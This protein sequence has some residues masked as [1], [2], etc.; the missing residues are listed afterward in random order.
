MKLQGIDISSILKP[1][2]KYVILTKKFVSSLADDYPVFISY[3]EDGIK[4]RELFLL[5]GKKIYTGYK[6]TVSFKDDG[7]LTSLIDEDE[8][9]VSLRAKKLEKFLTTE[10]RFLGFK[11]GKPDKILILH[12]VPVIGTNRKE[13]VEG[14]KEFLRLWNGIDVEDLPAKIEP[15]YKKAVKG[16]VIDID[17]AD[18]AFTI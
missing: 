2:V 10:L 12:D 9:V 6:Y 8:V 4:L 3:N 5:N 7:G 1:E 16:K 11:K 15:E 13:L 18:L 17:Y 14:I